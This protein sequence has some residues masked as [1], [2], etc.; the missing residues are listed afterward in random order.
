MVKGLAA[1]TGG[2]KRGREPYDRSASSTEQQGWLT[3]LGTHH[4]PGNTYA[5]PLILVSTTLNNYSYQPHLIDRE[6]EE[7]GGLCD[8]LK[9]IGSSRVGMNPGNMTSEPLLPSIREDWGWIQ[10]KRQLSDLI[11]KARTQVL[12][13]DVRTLSLEVYPRN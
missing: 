9:H 6:P 8:P 2:W 1:I 5:L 7:L 3:C 13:V 4:R 10:A 11:P 12:M